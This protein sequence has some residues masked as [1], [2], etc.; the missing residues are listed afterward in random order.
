MK[1][2][3]N[4]QFIGVPSDEEGA[5]RLISHLTRPNNFSADMKKL[6]DLCCLTEGQRP[7]NNRSRQQVLDGVADVWGR[8]RHAI[9]V[10]DR[11]DRMTLHASRSIP[12]IAKSTAA[13]ARSMAASLEDRSE[14]VAWEPWKPVAHLAGGFRIAMLRTG[15]GRF[16]NA[17]NLPQVVKI[18]Q[19]EELLFDDHSWIKVALDQAQSR[20][21]IPRL[22]GL[23]I[24]KKTRIFVSVPSKS[25]KTPPDHA[26][27]S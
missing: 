17:A 12:G 21:V 13:Y 11:F 5:A 26:I 1:V 23:Q 3:F 22:A 18:G 25:Q 20:V 24:P 16:F 8:L 9:D 4:A 19:I 15:R 6:R 7:Y 27:L 2:T 10:G 14:E